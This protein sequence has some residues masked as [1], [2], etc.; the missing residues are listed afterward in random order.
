[1]PSF[2]FL[3]TFR[4]VVGLILSQIVKDFSFKSR[5]LICF[6]SIQSQTRRCCLPLG[7]NN[8]ESIRM[9]SQNHAVISGLMKNGI[10]L[11]VATK[12]F[13]TPRSRDED[14]GPQVKTILS[15]VTSTQEEYLHPGRV[16]PNL[17]LS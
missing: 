8:Y 5:R 10:M 14:S 17:R 6:S 7:V 11:G 13:M 4:E 16:Y 9:M 12:F 2:N 3:I 1:M 15:P